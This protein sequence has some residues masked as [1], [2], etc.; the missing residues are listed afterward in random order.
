MEN[1]NVPEIPGN[2][3]EAMYEGLDLE[4]ITQL[5]M[6]VVSNE[7]AKL[8]DNREYKKARVYF[9]DLTDEQKN[10]IINEPKYKITMKTL[11]VSSI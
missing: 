1:P 7:F 11:R 4:R 6:E 9:K 5:E 3:I 2:F 10:Y 8:V